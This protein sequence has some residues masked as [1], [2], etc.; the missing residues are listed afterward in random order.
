M[1]AEVILKIT[2]S[3]FGTYIFLHIQTKGVMV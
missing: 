1:Q 3:Q 2:F